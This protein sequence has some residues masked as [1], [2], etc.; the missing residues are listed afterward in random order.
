MVRRLAAAGMG[1]LGKTNTTEFAYGDMALFGVTRNPWDPSRYAGGSSAGSAAAVAA[2]L[3][4]VATGSD[5]LGSIRVPASFSGVVGLK[6]TFGRVSRHGVTPLA[7]SLDHVGPIT[8]A[9]RDA[10][11][12]L[13]AMAGADPADPMTR[14]GSVP[15]HL[16]SIDD[17]IA[18]WVVGVPETGF[19][20]GL[21]PEVDQAVRA[22]LEVLEALGARLESIRL[23]HVAV[24]PLVGRAITMAE[25]F[26]AHSGPAPALRGPVRHARPPPACRRSAPARHRLPDC[27]TR[28]P[29]VRGG[30]CKGLR[31]GVRSGHAD[32]AVSAFSAA[33]QVSD[34]P[35]SG[36]FTSPFNL[37]GHP[38]ISIPCGFTRRGLPIG[39]QL[40]G[41]PFDEPALLRL[42]EAYERATEWHRCRPAEPTSPAPDKTGTT[43]PGRSRQDAPGWVA[44]HL[45]RQGLH[46]AD[47]DVDAIWQQCQSIRDALGVLSNPFMRGGC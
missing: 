41:R 1:L 12:L 22:A 9:V 33:A 13:N 7:W 39:L 2:G 3:A 14:P 5:T 34:P 35:D 17:G 32:D 43:E 45:A 26:A 40:V 19:W 46:L 30:A 4:I 25:G 38:A 42:A 20:E 21:D 44:E 47:E 10:A 11:L 16:A 23:P 36:V 29:G 24:L 6:P 27:R 18:G 15:D 31:E 28:S 37:S 8:R